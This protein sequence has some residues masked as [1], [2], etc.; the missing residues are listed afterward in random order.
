MARSELHSSKLP[1]VAQRAP[2]ADDG[3]PASDFITGETIGSV[4]AT[5][6]ADL[7]MLEEPVTIRLEPSSDKN[8]ATSF[9]VWVNGK[10]AECLINERWVEIV[11][12][13]VGMSLTIKRKYLG[14]IVSA[15]T[16]A[17]T[18]RIVDMDGE[19]PNNVVSRNTSPVHSFS[20][21]EDANPRGAAWVAELR[22]RN[23]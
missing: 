5:Y 16:D 14:V 8:A 18:T 11:Y 3:K 23:L 19:R 1:P 2:V 7:A 9:P 6:M 4:D 20:I 21:L 10:G 17:V 12:L 15:K 13:P 22:R